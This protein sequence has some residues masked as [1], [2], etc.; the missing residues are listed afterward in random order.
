MDPDGQVSA[1]VQDQIEDENKITS[2]HEEEEEEEDE[3]GLA[4]MPVKPELLTCIS[5]ENLFENMDVDYL[6]NGDSEHPNPD[7]DL[8]L[9]EEELYSPLSLNKRRLLFGNGVNQSFS[10]PDLNRIMM[11]EQL[12]PLVSDPEH[13]AD[14]MTGG[15]SRQKT[16]HPNQN[17]RPANGPQVV[18]AE[19]LVSAKLKKNSSPAGGLPVIQEVTSFV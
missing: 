14:H 18:Q 2:I 1:V 10:E 6:M 15:L 8:I 7:R 5:E 19:V 16:W 4:V 3:I 17:D 13:L 9:S 11:E 12:E